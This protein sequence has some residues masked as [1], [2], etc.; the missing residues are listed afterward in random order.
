MTS[1]PSTEEV[2]G[3]VDQLRRASMGSNGM[4][5]LL[6]QAADEIERLT[7]REGDLAEAL[8][9]C[10]RLIAQ[11]IEPDMTVG[12]GQLYFQLKIAEVNARALLSSHPVEGGG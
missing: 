8:G 10:R 9:T 6:C 11:L 5:R 7:A 4:R 2:V 1:T 3:L 12:V